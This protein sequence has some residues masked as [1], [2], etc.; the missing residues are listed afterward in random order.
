MM[1]SKFA[2]SAPPVP[3][4]IARCTLS[5]GMPASRARSMAVRSRAFPPGSPPPSRAATAIS[6]ANLLKSFPRTRSTFCFRI[7]MLCHLE[8][9][10]TKEPQRVTWANCIRD[11]GT[12]S[13]ER[14]V[15]SRSPTLLL[16]HGERSRGLLSIRSDRFHRDDVLHPADPHRRAEQVAEATVGGEGRLN[17]RRLH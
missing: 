5:L 2:P 10:D 3:R 16:G 8:C 9:P 11:R 13:R 17:L 1:V 15:V 12:G 7:L 6:R 14:Y 4:W